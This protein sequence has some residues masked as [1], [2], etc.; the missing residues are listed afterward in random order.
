[1]RFQGFNFLGQQVNP[2]LKDATGWRFAIGKGTDD[3]VLFTIWMSTELMQLLKRDG[4]DPVD[5][6]L[7]AGEKLAEDKMLK[8][9]RLW[10]VESTIEIGTK[11]RVQLLAAAG[12]A[13]DF[14]F[15]SEAPE[16]V[17]VPVLYEFTARDFGSWVGDHL[18][19]QATSDFADVIVDWD[20]ADGRRV[21]RTVRMETPI[22]GT[23]TR[24]VEA[25]LRAYEDRSRRLGRVPGDWVNRVKARLG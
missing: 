9:D 12:R 13:P 25:A 10:Q 22:G 4:L 17:G 20:Y 1:M 19:S 5:V 8:A 23:R 2:R 24:V 3:P 11:D 21:V 14:L 18:T 6:V 16:E 15:P 7:R